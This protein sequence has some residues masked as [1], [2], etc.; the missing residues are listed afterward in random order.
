MRQQRLQST[1]FILSLMMLA[2]ALAY[3]FTIV[4]K[5]SP[6][7]SWWLS[8]VHMDASLI[9]WAEKFYAFVL[10]A[11]SAT[12]VWK[13]KLIWPLLLLASLQGFNSIL[14]YLL[15]GGAFQEYVLATEATRSWFPLVLALYRLPGR[16]V[17]MWGDQ[18]AHG[19][20]FLTFAFHGMEALNQH[21]E[22]F[23]L[24]E[25]STEKMF[26]LIISQEE[27]SAM[28]MGIGLLDWV[29]ALVVLLNGSRD[30]LLYT[31]FW[32]F[33]TALSRFFTY[34]PIM[35]L[36]EVALRSSHFLLPWF[37][38]QKSGE[39]VALAT[40]TT[41]HP[42][43]AQTDW[44]PS[45][46]AVKVAGVAV[47]ALAFLTSPIAISEQGIN[48][49]QQIRHLRV[50]FEN[51]P[52]HQ[53]RIV[54]TSTDK[55]IRHTLYFDDVAHHDDLKDYKYRLTFN[56]TKSYFFGGGDVSHW[57]D[58][59]KL[60][61]DTAYYF[62]VATEDAVT[63]PLYFK[64]A[65][66]KAEN[67]KLLFGGDSRSDREMRRHMNRVM[68][69][70][71]SS[72]P[73]LVALV[74][75]G[76]YVENGLSYKQF[77]EW[78]DDH[79]ETTLADGRVL[80]IIPTRGNHEFNPKL[81]NA[82]FG[83]PG[84]GDNYFLTRIGD[85]SLLTLNTE[86]SHTG[87]QQQWL[88]ST[89]FEVAQDSRWVV[90]NYHRPA[91]PAV[92]SPGKSRQEWVPLFDQ[93]SVDLAVESD[94]HTLKRTAPIRAEVIDPLGTVY[95]GEGGL[96]VPQRIPAKADEWYF[97]GGLTASKHHV[98][99]LTV[100]AERMDFDV[101]DEGAL[102]IDHYEFLPKLRERRP[103]IIKDRVALFSPS[104]NNC[105]SF[106]KH[107][108]KRAQ[109]SI[110]LNN[111]ESTYQLENSGDHSWKLLS[112]DGLCLT[113][114]GRDNV[115]FKHCADDERQNFSWGDSLKSSFE[116]RDFKGKCLTFLSSGKIE[117]DQRFFNVKRRDCKREHD[118]LFNMKYGD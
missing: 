5:G 23:D 89:L 87:K 118:Q 114:D 37:L 72:N 100:S 84:N 33:I 81:L 108:E 63:D 30:S 80:P 28:M 71:F 90:T 82:I 14:A 53:A 45:A 110:C 9:P 104:F 58:V 3:A 94:G 54:V 39:D 59:E 95:V 61:P 91:F 99:L 11:L 57:I 109:H 52:A 69:E 78:L 88:E 116:V 40:V 66:L 20:L 6:I 12:A 62:V 29:V 60:R 98:Q 16:R 102:L 1:Q 17:Q 34:G 75:G 74:H 93:Y 25:N 83:N 4:V 27:F 38:Y 31:S 103:K 111:L 55:Q 47:L 79:Q 73:E 92:K 50:V 97:Q 18:L 26:G 8:K 85:F 70:V 67:L 36:M 7:S 113:A 112:R 15:G 65:P 2:T 117:D 56:Q 35:G 24:V 43:K 106:P 105:L 86:I 107:E 32:G 64:T 19:L 101:I 44:A 13:S 76:D 21:P 41:L 51:D 68:R 48:A 115:E 96:G 46:A 42:E 77:D 49:S 22:F 10:L